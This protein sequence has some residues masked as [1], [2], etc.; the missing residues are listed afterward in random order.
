MS[1]GCTS[2][3]DATKLVALL[4]GGSGSLQSGART[5]LA[6]LELP[7]K[8]KGK[9][10]HDTWR[11]ISIIDAADL[12]LWADVAAPGARTRRAAH[13]CLLAVTLCAPPLRMPTRCCC[14][15]RRLAGWHCCRLVCELDGRAGAAAGQGAA[16]PRRAPAPDRAQECILLRESSHLSNTEG[17]SMRGA[18]L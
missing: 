6:G 10:A 18:Q 7:G 2:K 16:Q 5:L 17:G 3:P 14:A 12:L 4:G 8:A 1:R 11:L 13:G 15:R 9:V